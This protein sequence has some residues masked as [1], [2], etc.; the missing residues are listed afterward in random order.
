[1]DSAPEALKTALLAYWGG[2][3]RLMTQLMSLMTLALDL[4]PGYFDDVMPSHVE[5]PPSPYPA[6]TL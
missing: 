4:P 2:V 6:F 5:P 3:T 1:M